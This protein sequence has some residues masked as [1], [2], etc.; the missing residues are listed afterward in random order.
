M[1]K[2]NFSPSENARPRRLLRRVGLIID[3]CM[4]APSFLALFDIPSARATAAQARLDKPRQNG[5]ARGNPHKG[6]HL[7]PNVGA[8][9][10]LGEA[11]DCVSEYDEHGCCE[12]G[13]DGCEERGEEGEEGD[14]KGGPSGVEGERGDEY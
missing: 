11:L 5:K 12:D 3:M 2:L 14:G 1:P 7:C 6:K 4:L 9:V 8:N 10:D 13:G